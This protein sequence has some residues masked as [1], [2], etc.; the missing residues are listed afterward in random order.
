MAYTNAA[1]MFRAMA[2]YSTGINRHGWG[3]TVGAI[4]RYSDEGVIPGT[5][6]NSAGYFLSLE[7][8]FNKKHSLT[9]T[10]FGAP[11]QRATNSA[12]Y[13]EAYE[14][15]DN[16]LYNPNWGWQ[17][18]RRGRARPPLGQLLHLGPQLV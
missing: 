9:L 11:T 3:L 6:Y 15:A 13:L 16:N 4:G 14:L 7:K 18:G 5:F 12:T 2:L 17:D 10:T 8:Q 1:Y